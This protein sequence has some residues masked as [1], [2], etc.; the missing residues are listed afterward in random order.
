MFNI[1]SFELLNTGLSDFDLSLS[2]YLIIFILIIQIIERKNN[3][4]EVINNEDIVPRWISV[5]SL[6]LIIIFWGFYPVEPSQF[7]YFQF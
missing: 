6:I 5:V 3:L 4:T 1:K 2:F 7:I